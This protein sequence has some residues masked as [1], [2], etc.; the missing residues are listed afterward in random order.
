MWTLLGPGQNVQYI[1]VPTFQGSEEFS[2]MGVLI[3]IVLTL[4]NAVSLLPHPFAIPL[5]PFLMDLW[6]TYSENL[7]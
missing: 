3:I 6:P 7:Q 1:G 5:N 2:A 4:K